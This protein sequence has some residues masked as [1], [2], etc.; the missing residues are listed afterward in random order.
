MAETRIATSAAAPRLLIDAGTGTIFVQNAQHGILARWDPNTSNLDHPSYTYERVEQTDEGMPA[1]G[2]F[3]FGDLEVPA[4][5]TLSAKG[6]AALV[7]NLAGS[8][9]VAGTVDVGATASEPG[10]GGFVGGFDYLGDDPSLTAFG[11][12][13]GGGMNA[14]D[15][16]GLQEDGGGGGAS[17]GSLGGSGGGHPTL[18][19]IPR[20]APGAVYGSPALEP[21]VGGSGGGNSGMPSGGGGSGGGAIQITARERIA[22]GLEGQMLA[23]GSGGKGGKAYLSSAECTGKAA[24]GGGGSGGA[25]LLEAPRIEVLGRLSVNGGGGG[26]GAS[27]GAHLPVA[28]R[29]G[30]DGAPGGN[31]FEAAAG[32]PAVG[33]GGAGGA[34]ASPNA[35]TGSDGADHPWEGGGGG[36]GLGRIAIRGGDLSLGEHVPPQAHVIR[37][38]G[39]NP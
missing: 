22:V 29:Y 5:T 7:L 18:D 24:G 3:S 10:P 34:G 12:G 31:G 15:P 25:I 16:D 17:F 8:A 21:L 36:G 33:C 35:P 2:I 30:A 38:R 14:P 27:G 23:T 6:D 4:G 20:G 37:L 13:P 39:D 19:N 32:G 11:A 9:V 26:A 1:L 28:E